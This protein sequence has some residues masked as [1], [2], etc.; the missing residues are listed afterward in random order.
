MIH[1]VIFDDQPCDAC[2]MLS[3]IAKR[4]LAP[5]IVVRIVIELMFGCCYFQYH[6]GTEG[7]GIVALVMPFIQIEVSKDVLLRCVLLNRRAVLMSFI[8]SRRVYMYDE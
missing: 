7:V 6:Y 8:T 1:L 3:F 2:V 5:Q 4:R